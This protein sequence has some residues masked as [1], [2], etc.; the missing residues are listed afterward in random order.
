MM[1]HIVT[2]MKNREKMKTSFS[3]FLSSNCILPGVDSGASM[4]LYDMTSG[5]PLASLHSHRLHPLPRQGQALLRLVIIRRDETV[6]GCD[7]CV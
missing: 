2:K 5:R 1:K 3:V 4:C 7:W 6:N